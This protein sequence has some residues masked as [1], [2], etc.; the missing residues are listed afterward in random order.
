MA[1]LNAPNVIVLSS[2]RHLLSYYLKISHGRFLP[3]N[4][5]FII[6]LII[7]FDTVRAIDGVFKETVNH[8]ER[9][10]FPGV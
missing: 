4:S 8:T 9:Q 5:Q 7:I 1:D 2:C 6:Q 3:L 10:I